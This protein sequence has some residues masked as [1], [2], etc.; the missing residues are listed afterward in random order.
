[1]ARAQGRAQ[2]A[3]GGSGRRVRGDE[4]RVVERFKRLGP[5]RQALAL[6]VKPYLAED[7][8]IDPER[9]E[10]AFISAE[11]ETIVEVVAAK[12]LYEGL[13]NHI[14]E[15]LYAGARLAG[16]DI[17]R[18]DEKPSAPALIDA[19]KD[20]GGLT[21]SQAETLR[22]LSRLRNDLQHASPTVQADEAREGIEALYRALPGIA[23]QALAWLE[24]H[25]VRVLPSRPSS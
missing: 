4:A 14:V 2:A 20:D 25:G 21:A 1:M 8:R 13:L 23:K 7:G 12:A 18:G 5:Q 24:R 3:G 16:L 22:K 10:A 11:P 15:M 19:V 6:A 17:A 9:W